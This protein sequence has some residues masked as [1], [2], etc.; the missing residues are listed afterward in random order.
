MPAA[1][2]QALGSVRDEVVETLARR[3]ERIM[4]EMGEDP[5]SYESPAAEMLAQIGALRTVVT[6]LR[7]LEERMKLHE[8][9]LNELELRGIDADRLSAATEALDA[10]RARRDEFAVITQRLMAALKGGR[11]RRRR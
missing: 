3:I 8:V 2:A 9:V 4:S 7:E 5:E 11:S 1:D 6:E 10:T